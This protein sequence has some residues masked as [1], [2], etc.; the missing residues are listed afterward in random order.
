MNSLLF[1]LISRREVILRHPNFSRRSEMRRAARNSTAARR[2]QSVCF[3]GND[4]AMFFCLPFAHHS[5]TIREHQR[6]TSPLAASSRIRK[7]SIVISN[8]QIS[9]RDQTNGEGTRQAAAALRGWLKR[10]SPQDPLTPVAAGASLIVIA[11]LACFVPAPRAARV[12]P[13]IA[14]RGD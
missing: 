9:T 4:R 14:L 5:L 10:V 7:P 8:R 2:Q 11:V 6:P 1:I 13:L 12:D 3:C